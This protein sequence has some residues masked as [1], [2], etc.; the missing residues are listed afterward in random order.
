MRIC[1]I[2]SEYPPGPHGGVGT[3]T[4]I[5]GRSLEASGHSVRVAGIYP[6]DYPA[7]KYEE[8]QGVRV[9][10]LHEP[11]SKFGWV[12]ARRSLYKLIA[13]WARA[14]DVELVEAPDSSGWFAGWPALPVPAVLRA[15]GSYSYFRREMGMPLDPTDFHLEKWSYRRADAWAAV[16]VYAGEV[17]SQL[18]SLPSGPLAVLYNPI[19]AGAAIVPV[20]A[21]DPHLIVY[22]GTLTAKKGIISLIDAWPQV[23]AQCPSAILEVLG[24]DLGGPNGG[25]MQ[26]FLAARLPASLTDSVV[27]R[28]HVERKQLF[29]A[30]SRARVAVFPSY[31]ETFG[32]A[33]L[34]AMAVGAP[35]IYSVRGPGPEVIQH[36]RDGLLVN[37][38]EPREIAKAIVR[39]LE[40]DGLAAR[41]ALAGHRR[42]REAFS[43]ETLIPQNLAFFSSVIAKF[44]GAEAAV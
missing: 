1:F 31:S 42:A 27:F 4:Q 26:A 18:F 19:E 15:S 2:C 32:M 13:T 16:S 21:R 22:T 6:K 38:A 14:G 29:S 8:D 44:R 23:R 10:R 43:L 20:D 7:A 33:P 36:E 39:L 40:D 30:L 3:I 28:G 24:K 17:T 11:Q 37:P 41:L 34:E 9:W 35:T 5:L 12:L 25:P